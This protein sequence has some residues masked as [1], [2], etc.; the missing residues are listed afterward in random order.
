[1]SEETSTATRSLRRFEDLLLRFSWLRTLK[2]RTRV[3]GL[4][5]ELHVVS[6]LQGNGH[7]GAMVHFTKFQIKDRFRN[8][9]ATSLMHLESFLQRFYDFIV[10]PS[11][12]SPRRSWPSKLRLGWLRILLW[13]GLQIMAHT[14]LMGPTK[15]P[16]G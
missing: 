8:H 10:F 4:S 14:S 5:L 6:S 12:S 3:F 11:P 7:G 9:N 2:P 16:A 13:A 15:N 1:M